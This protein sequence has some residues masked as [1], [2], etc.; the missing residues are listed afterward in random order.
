MTNYSDL[1]IAV[2]LD[3]ALVAQIARLTAELA[4]A[5]AERD[6]AHA[7]FTRATELLDEARAECKRLRAAID[8]GRKQP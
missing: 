3:A 5:R 7:D 4:E 6:G 1:A 8:A 2:Q